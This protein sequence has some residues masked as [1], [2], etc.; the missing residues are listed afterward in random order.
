MEQNHSSE[1]NSHYVGQ[2]IPQLLWNPKF[3]IVFTTARH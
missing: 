2:E 3:I 1:A